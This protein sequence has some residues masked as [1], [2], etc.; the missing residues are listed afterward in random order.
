MKIGITYRHISEPLTCVPTEETSKGVK[1]KMTTSYP[2]RPRKTPTVK[3]DYVQTG[4]YDLWT[5]A[6]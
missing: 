4:Y 2:N 6:K 1:V 5:V 3:T